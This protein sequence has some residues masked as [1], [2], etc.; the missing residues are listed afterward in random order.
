[1]TKTDNGRLL[2]NRR[3]FLGLS[4]AGCATLGGS[5][6]AWA[7]PA[8]GTRRLVFI[9]QR[10]AADGL[11]TIAPLG[12]PGFTAL[13]G[14][15]AEDYATGLS[16]G[17]GFTLHPAME[18][19]RMLYGTGQFLPVHAIASTYRDR[20]HFDGQNL[21]ELGADRPYARADGWLN[22][23]VGM[24]PGN[25]AGLAISPVLPPA[26]TGP[27]RATS[28]APSRLPDPSDAFLERI[29][30]LYQSDERLHTLWQESV[31]T[32]NMVDGLDSGNGR[33]AAQIGALAAQLLSGEEGARVAMIE[34]TGW[35]T[36]NAQRQRL[37]RQLGQLDTL[38]SSLHD[39]L[40]EDWGNTLVI[41]ATEFGRTAAVNGTMGT[42]H[43]TGASALLYGGTVKGGR[44]LA[45][46][47]GLRQQDLYEE[48]DLRP[49]M[50]LESLIGNAV[51][52]HFSLDQE[53]V[54]RTL[55]GH[56]SARIETSLTA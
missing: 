24:L 48:R 29:G 53:Q 8:T 10:G 17:D 34:T 6:L 13:R 11:G 30:H 44:L 55:F 32:R 23:L 50:S 7:A 25:S 3:G 35:D 22:R 56:V 33:N 52:G 21:L 14:A 49:T 15:M 54:M 9:L 43:G 41:V 46:W 27:N 2:A 37:S 40:G 26:L 5:R 1:M 4:L 42:D 20:S 39:G 31:E 18:T 51:A 28:Y 19:S 38:I 47:P 16:L 36:H 12:D 45:D